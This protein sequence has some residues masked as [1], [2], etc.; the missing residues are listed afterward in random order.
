MSLIDQ[1]ISELN[2]ICDPTAFKI[3]NYYGNERALLRKHDFE[4][5][6]V[7]L[8]TVQT[9]CNITNFQTIC[10]LKKGFFNRMVIDEMHEVGN[11][12]RTR[13]YTQFCESKGIKYRWAL[14]GTPIN[15]DLPVDLS[16]MCRFIGIK[17]NI[18]CNQLL[19]LP[20]KQHKMNLNDEI[21]VNKIKEFM[22]TIMLR[23]TKNQ[24]L[25]NNFPEKREEI[26]R[27]NLNEEEQIVY[28][29]FALEIQEKY[30]NTRSYVI[31]H[32]LLLKLR[33]LC[34]HSSLVF[35]SDIIINDFNNGNNVLNEDVLERIS[36][37]IIRRINSMESILNIECPVCFEITELNGGIISNCGHLFCLECLNEC[38]QQ[39]GECALCRGIC[40]ENHIINI[41]NVLN[42]KYINEKHK[43]EFNQ[44]KQ[45]NKN[46]IKNLGNNIVN[47][48]CVFDQKYKRLIQ[49]YSQIS[50]ASTKINLL[51]KKLKYIQ[52]NHKG[53]KVIIFSNFSQSFNVISERLEKE[54]IKH[55]QFH[56]KLRRGQRKEVLNEF[57]NKKKGF[58]GKNVLLI[59]AKC[60]S[61]G[62]NLM[63]SNHVI[64]LD[65]RWNP[66]LDNQAI[67]R[68]WR[69]GQNK[70]VYVTRLITNDTIEEK[71]LSLM[72]DKNE[73]KYKNMINLKRKAKLT[74]RDYD[75]LFGYDRSDNTNNR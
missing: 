38:V 61:V 42:S 16:G 41:K 63:C 18:Y 11:G 20:I 27:F 5:C 75:M 40:D 43:Y 66:A 71:I 33:K 22:G 12:I 13:F 50:M 25:A 59:S 2:H 47:K 49:K 52:I 29:R 64:F 72:Q 6:D 62:L 51:I 67:G 15:N 70:T 35:N 69:L 7:V 34:N 8:S 26:I 45:E 44:W 3:L 19:L 60:A 73:K 55:L 74:E 36:S 37:G 46:I 57:K 68:C 23:R 24:V 4:S 14:T 48:V 28:N 39:K 53:D 65:P 58:F 21:C 1:W 56:S 10:K 30:L 32:S 31:I 17:Y 9:F 54:N